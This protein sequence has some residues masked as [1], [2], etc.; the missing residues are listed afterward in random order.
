[1]KPV[2]KL[3]A[4]SVFLI[5]AGAIANTPAAHATSIAAAEVAFTGG[6]DDLC[7]MIDSI[8]D[9]TKDLEEHVTLGENA[10]YLRPIKVLAGKAK[11]M[12][13]GRGTHSIRSIAACDFLIKKIQS[14]A[15]FIEGRYSVNATFDLAIDLETEREALS[16]EIE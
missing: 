15:N 8:I 3:V 14:A 1:M 16:K 5:T 2:L 7:D 9:T 10:T 4:L 11:A 6:E 13:R 12:I